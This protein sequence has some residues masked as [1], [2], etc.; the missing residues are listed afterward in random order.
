MTTRENSGAQ[1]GTFRAACIQFDVR[2]GEVAANLAA[3]R[4]GIEA[5]AQE[6]CRLAVLPEMWPTSFMLDYPPGILAESEKAE[7][8]VRELSASLC[9]V[10]VGSAVERTGTAPF[11][12]A[13]VFDH[14]KELGHYRKI[15]MFSPNA[16][17]RY[18]ASGDRALVVDTSLGRMGVAVCYDIRFPELT[19]WH[20]H[21]GV[22]ILAVPAQW[23]EAR[24][25]H[26]KTLLRARAIENEMFVVG[27]NRTGNEASL[28]S[29]EVLPFPGDG[30]I[31]DPT[32]EILAAGTGTEA[33][34]IAEIELRRVRMV[35]RILPVSRD[36]RP[37]VYRRL[38]DEVYE[39][40]VKASRD[41]DD[42][43]EN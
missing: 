15:H 24:A 38:F 27:C 14:G 25:Q 42:S 34:V 3:A 2:R 32:G 33:P 11:N 6:G 36:Q 10:I 29:D 13:R 9:M 37:A 28:K 39:D 35:R 26:W 31:V 20:F 8:E 7:Q 18:H 19:R 12:T 1:D 22:E 17:P 23:P 30:R 16:E 40:M 43:Q 4:A 21:K 5:A 41:V